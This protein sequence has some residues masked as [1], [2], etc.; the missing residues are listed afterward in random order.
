MNPQE[1]TDTIAECEAV[2]ATEVD[3][4]SLAVA[5]TDLDTEPSDIP[6]RPQPS[7]KLQS[8]DEV[9]QNASIVSLPQSLSSLEK[10]A[11]LHSLAESSPD[12]FL[13]ALKLMRG[14]HPHKTH[15]LKDS[16]VTD[17]SLPEAPHPALDTPDIAPTHLTDDMPCCSRASKGKQPQRNAFAEDLLD[18]EAGSSS[19]ASP[20]PPRR[21]V[22]IEPISTAGLAHGQPIPWELDPERGAQ[23]LPIRF[24][25]ALGRTL[26][27]PWKRA[28]TWE[29]RIA[30]YGMKM[31]IDAQFQG[32]DF[33]DNPP[34]NPVASGRY[35]LHVSLPSSV[36]PPKR[37]SSSKHGSSNSFSRSSNEVPA[38]NLNDSNHNASGSNSNHNNSSHPHENNSS[39]R[40]TPEVPPP[41]LQPMVPDTPST[42]MRAMIILPEFWDDLIQ[43]GS[44]VNMTMWPPRPPRG[45]IDIPIVP[46]MLPGMPPPA[47]I[48]VPNPPGMV[49]PPMAPPHP[50]IIRIRDSARDTRPRTRARSGRPRKLRPAY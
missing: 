7:L 11:L 12:G 18:M 45:T 43:P 35:H 19:Q 41:P 5:I 20:P 25:D 30:E 13:A 21:N 14:K 34:P 29:A 16:V 31:T 6:T 26:L 24:K 33:M 37:K 22:T 48:V 4:R 9:V 28:K 42:H 2:L 32:L 39:N 1:G 38:N 40:N 49:M 3:L 10:E 23:K 46:N 44:Y 50:R 15:F 8:L 17:A 36:E 27:I 47:P